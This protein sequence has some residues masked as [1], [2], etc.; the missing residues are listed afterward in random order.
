MVQTLKATWV[1][2]AEGGI[3][4]AAV[5]GLDMVDLVRVSLTDL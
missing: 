5:V 3:M 1:G 4:E 2:E